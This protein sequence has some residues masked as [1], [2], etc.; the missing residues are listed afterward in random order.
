[1]PDEP[2]IRWNDEARVVAIVLGPPGH[3]LELDPDER[4][5]LRLGRGRP[6]SF[7]DQREFFAWWRSLLREARFVLDERPSA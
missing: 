1:M 7:E 6:L 2:D 4:I 3:L 5:T